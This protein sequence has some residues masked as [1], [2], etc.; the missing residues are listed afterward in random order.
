[1]CPCLV[2]LVLG[3]G[4]FRGSGMRLLCMVAMEPHYVNRVEELVIADS[5][6]VVIIL[7]V[8]HAC[9][10][11]CAVTTSLPTAALFKSERVEC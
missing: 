7:M 9:T 8:I 5:G 3:G 4:L 6:A 1:M 10:T 2:V 11:W